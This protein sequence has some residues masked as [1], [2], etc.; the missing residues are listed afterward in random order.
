MLYTI[1]VSKRQAKIV[2]KKGKNDEISCLKSSYVE[3]EASA[4]ACM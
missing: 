2:P 1:T 3:L 4:G